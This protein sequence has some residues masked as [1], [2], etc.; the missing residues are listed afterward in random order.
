VPRVIKGRRTSLEKQKK[1]SRW[2]ER[3]VGFRVANLPGYELR[4]EWIRGLRNWQLQN[5]AKNGFR[6]RKEDFMSEV[7]SV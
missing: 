5:E 1:E 3:K 7:G 6:L 2:V 4:I